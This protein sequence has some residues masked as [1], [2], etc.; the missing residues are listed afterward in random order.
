MEQ[1]GT[2]NSSRRQCPRHTR[3]TSTRCWHTCCIASRYP[4]QRVQMARCGRRNSLYCGWRPRPYLSRSQFPTLL[5][6][7]CTLTRIIALIDPVVA[8]PLIAILQPLSD[9][10]VGVLSRTWIPR[11]NL[12]PVANITYQDIS[13]M[14]AT[15]WNDRSGR[16]H[17]NL[18][19]RDSAFTLHRI[20]Q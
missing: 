8:W 10:A 7:P 16:N 1:Q 18:S 11:T 3:E 17:S 20:R 13:N 5:V 15:L 9:C 19:A 12:W 6:I 14:D 2:A 4:T